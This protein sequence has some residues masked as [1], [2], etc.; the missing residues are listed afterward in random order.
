MNPEFSEFSGKTILVVEDDET[1]REVLAAEFEYQG[2]KTLMAAGGEKALGTL[3]RESVDAIV[4]DIR[5]PDGSGIDLLRAVRECFYD[6]PP[7]IFI[8]GFSDL[9]L[10]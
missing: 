7:L 3:K 1:L 2:L 4:S 9:T 6:R 5:M 8:S 10:A